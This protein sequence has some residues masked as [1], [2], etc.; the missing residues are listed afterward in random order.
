MSGRKYLKV[1]SKNVVLPIGDPRPATITINL[2]SG[3]IE[4]I[5]ER[6]VGDDADQVSDPSVSLLDAGDKYVLPGLVDAHVHL[7]EPGRTEW[8]GF[9][10]GTRAAVSGGI[11]T[12]VDMPLNSI[13]PT[14]TKANLDEKRNVARNQCWA[15][16]AFWGG[17][18][19]GNQ[20]DLKS[21]VDAG[22]KGFKCFLIES[23]VDEFPCVSEEDLKGHMEELQKDSERTVLLFHA[24][25]DDSSGPIAFPSD[26]TTNTLYQTFLS[27][28]PETLEENAIDL[29]IGL[30]GKYPSLRCHIVHLSAASALEKIRAAK[31][32]GLNLTVETCFHYLCLS[33]DDIP[34][35]K[36][37][38]KCCPPIRNNSNRERLWAALMDG[39]IDCVVSD[40]SPCVVEL[41]KLEEG[42]IM[43]AWGG[44]NSLGLGL[45]L[46]WT[47]GSKAERGAT[48]KQVVS[49]MSEKTAKHAGLS[50]TKGSLSKG[51]DGD[52]VIWDPDAEFEVSKEDFHFK[53]KLSA[54]EGLT[55]KGVV[56]QTF[57]RGHM[58]YD[59]SQ[60]GF[61][62]LDPIGNLL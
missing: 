51:L 22:V 61:D 41:K 17:V 11:T 8:E 13:P 25:L 39:T 36:P 38:F 43:G 33:A 23:G 29:I 20:G 21:L 28:R 2:A 59:R 32:K 3:K 48:L 34:R 42:D 35:G 4:D 19:P 60:N 18:I 62:G 45:S 49:W 5:V 58:V 57:L 14:T 1:T 26:P 27:S 9:E 30:Q 54:Y 12:V 52:L 10:T 37:Q 16:V 53:N 50:D 31:K 24:E 44:I 55:L 56:Q 7:N 15:D 46:L 6:Y 40:H 47:E